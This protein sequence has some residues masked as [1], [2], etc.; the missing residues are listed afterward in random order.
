MNIKEISTERRNSSTLTIDQANSLEIVQLMNKEDSQVP[1]AIGKILPEIASAIDG[2]TERMGLGGRLI[3][4]GAGT[5]G[6]LG[7]LD[8]SECPPTFSTDPEDVQALI[9]GGEAAITSSFEG[10]EDDVER[11]R[12]DL[13]G[14]EVR[15]QDVVVGI[16]ASGRTPYTIGAMEL[17]KEK[18]ALVLA[19]VCSQDSEMEKAADRTLVAEVGPEVI[20]GSTRLKAGT[21]QKLILNMLSTGTMIKQGKVYSNLMV[22]V[23]PTNKK[24]QIRS[25]HIIMEATGVIEEEAA[26][27]L[28]EYGAVKPAILS[29]LTSL[30]G[31]HVHAALTKHNGHIGKAIQAQQKE[32]K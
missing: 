3:Y 5:S 8:A 21:A 10:A 11:G 19:L 6:R 1:Q 13:Q 4:V 12:A 16:A 29:L 14:R 23:Q 32:E 7:I 30:K 25:K 26:Q 2:I 15:S 31:D 27:A 28:V 20:T 17:A 22:D 24:L 9:A 18:G